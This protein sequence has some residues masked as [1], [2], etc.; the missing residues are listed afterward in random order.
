MSQGFLYIATGSQYI[1]EA[2]TSVRSLKRHVT[3]EKVALATDEDVHSDLFDQIISM[4]DLTAD[5]SSSNIPPKL[6][7]FDKTVFLDTDTY[8]CEDI[9]G[10]FDI[11]NEYDLAATIAPNQNEVPQIP[12]PYVEYNTGVIAYKSNDKIKSMMRIWGEIYDSWREKNAV[13]RNQ[14]SFTKAVYESNISTHTLPSKYNV[15]IVFP[16]YLC[17]DAKI[18]HGRHPA[19]LPTIAE[20]INKSRGFR[21]F[22]P[23]SYVFTVNPFKLVERGSLR[24]KIEESLIKDGALQTITKAPKYIKRIFK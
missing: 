6:S 2:K 17:G 9:T 14:P 10:L 11:L 5:F 21:V 7:P 16:G 13:K 1:S 19:G 20:Y 23:N 4:E 22:Y 8:I 12:S 3:G 15:R 24:Y 18:V